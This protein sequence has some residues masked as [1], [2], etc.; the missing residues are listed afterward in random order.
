MKRVIFISV[1]F[2]LISVCGCKQETSKEP[3]VAKKTGNLQ[4]IE[5]LSNYGYSI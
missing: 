1:L 3:E 5:H 2:A 4:R